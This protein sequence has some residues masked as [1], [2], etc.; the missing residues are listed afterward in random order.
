MF[1]NK[2][3]SIKIYYL[4]RDV[5]N[6]E[7]FL[8]IN[9]ICCSRTSA[10]RDPGSLSEAESDEENEE[11]DYTVYECPGLASVSFALQ[12]IIISVSKLR[13]LRVPIVLMIFDN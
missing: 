5:R 13:G 6:L 4:L 12:A 2:Y 1:K 7:Y 8:R 10:T 11:G 9:I 3:I